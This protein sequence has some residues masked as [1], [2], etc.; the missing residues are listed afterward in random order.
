[1][2]DKLLWCIHCGSNRI[3]GPTPNAPYVQCEAC[4]AR[5]PDM[6]LRYGLFA[7]YETEIKPDAINSW[8]APVRDFIGF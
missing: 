5:G 2:S 7:D 1:M 8:N 4:G 3:T 6:N